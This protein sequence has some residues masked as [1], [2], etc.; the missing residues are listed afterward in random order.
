MAPAYTALYFLLLTYAYAQ[1]TSVSVLVIPHSQVRDSNTVIF[2]AGNHPGI[3]NWSPNTVPLERLNDSVWSFTGTFPTGTVLQF[4]ITNGT[5]DGEALYDSISVPRNSVITVTKDTT[6]ILRPLLWKS[7]LTAM[8]PESA[9]RGKVVYHRQMAGAG[10]NYRR[11][12]MVWLPP[13]YESKPSKRYP[14]LYVHDGQNIFDPSTA[15]TG[16]DWR[17]DEIAD[18][19]IALKV[20]GEI[21]VI[22][23]YNTPDRLQEYSDSPLGSAYIN[24]VASVLKPMIDSAYR[25][26]PDRHHTA[27]MGSSMGALSSLLFV[28]KRPDVFG[29]AACLSTSFWYDNEKTLNEVKAYDGRKKDIRIYIDCGGKEKDLLGDFRRMAD[30]LQ[31]KGFTKGKDLEYFLDTHGVHSERSWANRVWRPLVFLFGKK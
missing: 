26:K 29:A 21:I 22:G 13:S 4:K 24:F 17:V 7:Q 5:W 2:I 31:R 15:F 16:Y 11:D 14:V 1:E 18:S 9:I 10:L 12:V 25:T 27:V 8:K 19:L 30:I 28:W 3:G 23:V 6:V 20:I